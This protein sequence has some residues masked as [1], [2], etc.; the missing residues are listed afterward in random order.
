MPATTTVFQAIGGT[1][2]NATSTFITDVATDTIATI[3][4]WALASLTLYV[5]LWGYMVMASKIEEPFTTSLFKAMK[6]L[7]VGTMALNADM[8]LNNVVPAFRGIEEGLTAAFGGAARG[9][10]IYA[11]LDSN[12]S[13]GLELILKCQEK[14]NEAGWT[15]ITTALGWYLI[16]TIIAVGFALVVVF[17]GIAVVMSTVY[18]KILFAIGPVFIMCLMFPITAKF[19]DAWAGFVLNH[20]LIVALTA[21]V[22]TLGVTI[23]DHQV[24]KM[25]FDSEQNMLAVS[26]ELLVVAAILYAVVKGVLPAASALAGGLTMAVMGV[27][28]IGRTAANTARTTANVAT[29]TAKVGIGVGKAGYGLGKWAAS[30]LGGSNTVKQGGSGG[31]E[32][33]PAY[34]RQVIE[35]LQRHG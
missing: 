1:L 8:Y 3:Y 24:S 29:G 13:K 10:S 32:Y 2:D 26:L 21:V 14:A 22:L 35:K 28:G 16:G 33:T 19:F 11:T 5:M 7:F 25:A 23:Y 18:L 15:E 12:L 17:G 30:K 31:G 20:I 4:P 34:R 6:V 27:T 9:S